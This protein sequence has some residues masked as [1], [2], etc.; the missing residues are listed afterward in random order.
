MKAWTPQSTWQYAVH[1]TERSHGH[2]NT[3]PIGRQIKHEFCFYCGLQ[4]LTHITG[5]LVCIQFFTRRSS[6]KFFVV[7]KPLQDCEFCFDRLF[8]ELQTQHCKCFRLLK[9]TETIL[10]V[11]APVFKI[12]AC[13]GRPSLEIR[14]QQPLSRIQMLQ[15]ID[16][17]HQVVSDYYSVIHN[18]H[19]LRQSG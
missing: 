5:I 1:A 7:V 12:V 17:A 13:D 19:L 11:D 10:S 18:R 9:F 4:H 2:A 14:S 16:T 6:V 8:D 3:V 15:P